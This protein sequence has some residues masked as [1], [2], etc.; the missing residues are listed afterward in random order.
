[1]RGPG[2]CLSQC[3]AGRYSTGG[4]ASLRHLPARRGVASHRWVMS[5]TTYVSAVSGCLQSRR[6][7]RQACG[8]SPFRIFCVSSVSARP[9]GSRAQFRAQIWFQR[10]AFIPAPLTASLQRP[11]A[12]SRGNA[13]P[14]RAGPA[15]RCDRISNCVT[16]SPREQIMTDASV[17]HPAPSAATVADIMHPPVTTVNQND[18]VAA[19]AYLMERA[20]KSADRTLGR[21]VHHEAV[22][23]GRPRSRPPS[24]YHPGGA[25][26]RRFARLDGDRN[27]SGRCLSR[28]PCANPCTS[29]KLKAL[30]LFEKG[31]L[32]LVAGE[33]FE[34]STSGL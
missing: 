8:T 33:G 26:H 25:D 11:T 24:R 20:A 16:G 15:G 3:A 7:P 17:Q 19:A 31:P 21:R 12:P 4:C 2:A 6:W 10:Q 9:A 27:E 32:A 18:H 22:C 34:P 13:T 5:H 23:P 14:R 1:M 29:H 28:R 30:S